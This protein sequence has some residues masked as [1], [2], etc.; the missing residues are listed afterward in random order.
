MGAGKISIGMWMPSNMLCLKLK[1]GYIRP[2]Q[3]SLK[4]GDHELMNVIGG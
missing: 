3:K 4:M 1:G 2:Q